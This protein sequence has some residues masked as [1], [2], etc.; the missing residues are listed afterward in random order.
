MEGFLGG[1]HAK[2]AGGTAVME[3]QTIWRQLAKSRLLRELST[4]QLKLLFQGIVGNYLTPGQT[5]M[6]RG[7]REEALFIIVGGDVVAIATDRSGV[8]TEVRTFGSGQIFGEGSLLEHRPWPATYKAKTKATLLRLTAAGLQVCLTG[9]PDPRGFLD[10]LR[11]EQ[12]DR[13]VSQLVGRLE[14]H[15]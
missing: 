11:R 5:V 9:N 3:F 14:A 4:D 8:A 6:E 1:L 13:E 15:A 2:E 10:I 7:S 12:T